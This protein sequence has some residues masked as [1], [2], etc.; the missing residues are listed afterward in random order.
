[1]KTHLIAIRFLLSLAVAGPLALTSCSD[2]L[3]AQTG[4]SGSENAQE[5]SPENASMARHIASVHAFSIGPEP[6]A[7]LRVTRDGNL[8]GAELRPDVLE[9]LGNERALYVLGWASNPHSCSRSD[10]LFFLQG[11]HAMLA[12]NASEW[13]GDS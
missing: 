7:C 5:W 12:M 3:S 1:M 13:R 8:I 10:Y 2:Q 4:G 6:D 9:K 11:L